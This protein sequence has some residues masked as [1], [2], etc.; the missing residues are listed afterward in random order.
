M[1]FTCDLTH[2]SIIEKPI[3]ASEF[4]FY[5][6]IGKLSTSITNR[7]FICFNKT[8]AIQID[9]VAYKNISEIENYLFKK[10][11][12]VIIQ[13]LFPN[14]DILSKIT[15][16][17]IYLTQHDYDF[18]A[19]LNAF[20]S[21]EN[22]PKILEYVYKNKNIKFILNSEFSKK[23]IKDNFQQLRL[24]IEENRIHIIPNFIFEDFFQKTNHITKKKYQ[25]VYASGWNKGIQ[26]IIRLFDYI[27]TQNNQFTLV[28]MSPGYEYQ[29]YENLKMWI[30]ETYKNNVIILGPT[31]KKDYCKVIQESSCVFAPPFPETFGCVFSESYY[32]GTAV[33]AD[34]RSG[35][36]VEIIGKENISDYNDLDK[37]YK[38]LLEILERNENIQLH[39]KYIFNIHT[40]KKILQ[41]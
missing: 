36:V 37:T 27:L 9:N 1:D 40:W 31:P 23:Y 13:R 4:I 12:I 8:T 21:D 24:P 14:L 10:N 25:L 3:G 2:T 15:C 33:I 38:K 28:L 5:T 41:I 7:Q 22:K 32:L 11:D 30:E 29:K 17:H 39:N 19:I 20:Q 6:T 34:Q 26:H 35:A 16:K 18:Y